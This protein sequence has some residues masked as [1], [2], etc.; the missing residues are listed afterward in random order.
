MLRIFDLY[1][2][3]R[4]LLLVLVEAFLITSA[5]VCGLGIRFWGQAADFSYYIR[6][7]E[8]VLQA[9]VFVAA[10]QVC[11]Y[12]CDLYNL[13]VFRR[14]IEE[15]TAV[16]QSIGAACLVL[17]LIYFVFPDLLLGRGVF[18]ISLVLAPVF[19]V[20][21]R[22]GLDRVWRRTGPTENILILG[23]G[24]LAA[25]VAEELHERQD[26]NARVA[27]F[28]PLVRHCAGQ[29][30]P[31]LCGEMLCATVDRERISR[32]V[33]AVED[34]RNVL[35]IRELVRLRVQG[36]RVDDAH[37]TISALTGRIW[38][39]TVKPSW[40]VFT[41]GFRRSPVTMIAKRT[42]DLV[43]GVVG[44]LLSLPVM[45]VV[46]IVIRL[47]SKGPIIYRQTRVGLR[48]K[49]FQLLK[50]RSMRMDA[51]AG[52]AQWAVKNDPRVTRVGR[53]LRRYRLDELPQWVNVIRAD[54]SLVGPRP[55]RPEF[56]DELRNRISYYD[57]RHSVRPGLTGWAQVRYR[58]GFTVE[59]AIR[60]LEYD[61][62]YLKN[63][64]TPF[65]FAIL[66]KTVRIVF[67]GEGSQ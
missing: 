51:E 42:I 46:A 18:F 49:C 10:F 13:S 8:F 4:I 11:F 29:N 6:L 61:L 39:E 57:E 62:F 64:S 60:K 41:D 55:E 1:V 27:G 26:L 47:D 32:I 23:N 65:D 50:F 66:L 40:F 53:F 15:V 17:A 21:S 16:G 44:L 25:A 45:A 38:L 67:T 37:T 9:F 24:S 54:M 58:Y 3:R 20:V 14:S 59:D 48:G 19:L 33:V 7:R 28:F 52:G 56:V 12:C 34:R 31:D 63:M 35:P 36:V 5:V 30:G 2:S 43:A 22:R